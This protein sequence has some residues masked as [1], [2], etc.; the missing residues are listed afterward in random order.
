MSDSDSNFQVF[1]PHSITT[2]P[3]SRCGK[4]RS[5]S[6]EEKDVELL[7]L[8]WVREQDCKYFFSLSRHAKLNSTVVQ[9]DNDI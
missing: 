8:D 7:T 4:C 3:R 2:I 6:I 1:L 9:T 5:E